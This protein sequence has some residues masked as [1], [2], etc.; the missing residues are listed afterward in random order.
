MDAGSQHRVAEEVE[1]AAHLWSKGSAAAYA[2]KCRTLAF[3]IKKNEALREQVR[4]GQVAA[5]RLVTF[6]K[7]GLAD[8]AVTAER[9]KMASKLAAEVALDYR[10]RLD[11]REKKRAACGIDKVVSMNRCGKCKSQNLNNWEKQTRSADEPMTQ[12]FMCLDC[13]HEWRN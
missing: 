2:D 12:F 13:E 11:V 8:A 1:A 6:D 4:S 9:E 5:E 10:Q 7:D 3:N